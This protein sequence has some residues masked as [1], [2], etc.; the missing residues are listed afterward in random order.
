MAKYGIQG[1]VGGGSAEGGAMP[2]R[3]RLQAAHAGSASTSSSAASV[4]RLPLLADSREKGMKEATKYYEENMKMFGEPASY[5]RLEDQIEIMRDPSA[6]TMAAAHR[7]RGEG[8][9]LLCSNADDPSAISRRWRK[10]PALDRL[11]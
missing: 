3:R 2:S 9:R 11:Q 10:Y 6:P 5:A 7:G 4:L 1:M 8:R